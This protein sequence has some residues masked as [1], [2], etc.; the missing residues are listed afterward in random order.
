MRDLLIKRK[1]EQKGMGAFSALMANILKYFHDF[2][3]VSWGWSIILLTVLIKIILFPTSLS[4]ARS[5][6]AMKKIQPKMKEIQEKYKKNPEEMQRRTLELYK[7][8]NVNPLGGCLPMLIQIP[9]LWALFGVLRDPQQFNID[10]TSATFLGMNLLD[11]GYLGLAIISGGSTFLQQKL[12]SPGGDE[13][14]Q[15]TMLYV[16]PFFLGW[17]TYSLT[18]GVGL[19]WVASTLLGI[20]QQWILSRF[21]AQENP[22]PAGKKRKQPS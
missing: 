10:M 7:T 13:S 21:I 20:A 16:M 12:F 15:S 14:S 5:I 1:G 8:H 6:E 3:G 17:L 18:A 19:Y 2:L 9:F 4:Q 11:K 22:G